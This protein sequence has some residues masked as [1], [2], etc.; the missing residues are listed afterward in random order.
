MSSPTAMSKD[1]MARLVRR[2]VGT[3]A[4]LLMA[5]SIRSEQFPQ[6]NTDRMKAIP[7]FVLWAWE[8]PEDL[9]FINPNDTAVAFLANTIRLHLDRVIVRPR[10]QPLLVPKGT[11]LI[12][13][14][15]IE[16]DSDAAFDDT[17]ITDAVA[18]ILSRAVLP[19]V[20]AVQIDFDAARSQRPFYRALLVELR[21]RLAKEL[22]ISIT[23][24]A[25]W[26]LDDDWISTLPVDEAV[27]MLFRMGAGTNDVVARLTSG[28]DFQAK[29]C[30][31]SLGIS[32]DER[33]AALPGGR[34]LYVFR[35]RSWTEQSEL[36]F[37]A[38]VQP[39][40]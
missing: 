25:S 6:R 31:E 30:Q 11:K 28:R 26:C 39:W 12:A 16:T 19:R 37:L 40:R 32:T 13:V 3:L 15:R 36:A 35:S 4:C 8:R 18:A 38:E 24:L 23:A 34:R 22:P 17:Q 2:S 33:W 9:R 27:P 10:L 1:V 20:V 7:S 14:V 21:Q 5:L 29:L